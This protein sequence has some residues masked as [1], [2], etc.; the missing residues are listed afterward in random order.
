MNGSR[1]TQSLN[2]SAIFACALLFCAT[3]ICDLQAQETSTS[4]HIS[5]TANLSQRLTAAM[6][7]R[8]SGDPVAIGQASKRV[9]ALALAEMARLRL[10]EKAYEQALR[11]NE[12]SL[13]FEDAPETRV[14]LALANLYAKNPAEAAKQA[15]ATIEMDPQNYLAWAIK[16]EVLLESR[17]YTGASETFAKSLALKR[18]PES[19]YGLGLAQL[20]MGE[21]QKAAETFVQFLAQVGEFGWSRVLVGRAYQGQGLSQEAEAEFH[22]GLVLDPT[23]PNANYFWAITILQG[24]GWNATPEV[25]S[26]LQAELRLNPRHFEANYMLGSLASAARNDT[27]S[28]RYLRLASEIN[29]SVPETWILLG[30]NAQRR[31]S[32]QAA[33]SY[34]RN[35]IERSKK[36]DPKEHFELRKAYFGLGRLLIASGKT[37][38]GEESLAKAKE[39]QVQMLAENR[40]KLTV[41]KEEEREGMGADAPYIP[42]ADS[43][44]HPY[45]PLSSAKPSTAAEKSYTKPRTAAHPRSDPQGKEE[46]YLA[47]VLGASFNDLATAEALESNYVDALGHYR[48]AAQWDPKIP[49]LQRNLGLAAYFAGQPAEAIRLLSKTMVQAPSDSHARAVLGLAHFSFGNFARTV[50]TITPIAEQALQD[51]ELGLSWAT[52]LNQTGNKRAAMQALEQL[53]RSGKLLGAIEQFE[54]TAQAQPSNLSYHLGLEEAYRKAGRVA[55]ADQQHA[56]CES[57][58]SGHAGP[59][60]SVRKKNQG[61]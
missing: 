45:G 36:L 22:K 53:Q 39:L 9:L 4:S 31:K 60:S 5:S 19:L 58:I 47:E 37:K 49:G 1:P 33:M 16:G 8:N 17:D 28:D 20:G 3:T 42:E 61:R 2:H 52:S 50:Q 32:N 30:L 57:L 59:L 15:S 44:R 14:E 56:I 26:H 7:A 34:F 27:E 48:E 23:T 24:N 35:A 40:N 18:D 46:A 10:D 55:D 29:P 41:T 21:K 51:P 43:D 25:Y 54:R 12:E 38:E 13:R 11:L 6:D